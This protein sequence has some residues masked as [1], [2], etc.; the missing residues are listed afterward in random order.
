MSYK[1]VYEKNRLIAWVDLCTLCNAACP[2]CHRTNPDGLGKAD[3]LDLVQWTIDDFKRM[4]PADTID[5]IRRFEICGTWGDPIMNRDLI[6]ICEYIIEHS[7]ASIMINTNGSTQSEEWWWKLVN[8]C[9]HRLEVVFALDGSTQEL[10]SKYRQKTDLERVKENIEIVSMASTARIY[11]I[12]FKHNQH[13]WKNIMELG[14]ELGA[15]SIFMTVSDR[16]DDWVGDYSRYV[17]DGKVHKLERANL[18]GEWMRKYNKRTW[19]YG[20]M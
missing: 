17:V 9:R 11:T 4:F 3:F 19:T 14:R 1:N 6:K 16:F 5:K 2:Q 12:I 18:G 8:T 13:D 15:R 10:H 7:H 20:K